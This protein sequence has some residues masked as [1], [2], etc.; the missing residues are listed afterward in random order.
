MI[1]TKYIEQR[2]RWLAR[3]AILFLVVLA[4][5]NGEFFYKQINYWWQ[6]DVMSREFVM[7]DI[8]GIPDQILIKK[9]G[10]Q[11]P[12]IY[13]DTVEEPLLQK[14]LEDG[15]VHYLGT[16]NPGEWGNAYFFGHSSNLPTRPGKYKT[17]FALLTQLREGDE[18][19]ITNRAGQLFTYK[20]FDR[21]IVKSTQLEVLTQGDRSQ[22]IITLQASYPLGM[23]LWRYIIVAEL[24]EII[25]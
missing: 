16:A 21:K 10:V 20:I 3:G 25:F 12:L 7:D 9:I 11:A 4:L 17:V 6:H 24:V 15:V 19:D 8:V 5:I 18:I 14:A 1:N 22:K 23:A 13:V 2:L